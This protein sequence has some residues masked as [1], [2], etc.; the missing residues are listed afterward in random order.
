LYYFLL[1]AQP[2]ETER[3]VYEVVKGVLDSADRM[4]EELRSYPGA[5]Q[6][7]REA[8]SNPMNEDLQEIAWREVVPLVGKL[9]TFYEY[10]TEL[11]SVLPQLLH[12]L[13]AGPDTPIEHLEKHQALAKQ[14]AEIL[15]FTLKFDDL[16]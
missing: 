11:E 9:K 5:S 3:E 7:I 14:F 15:H 12:A 10:A 6:A 4:L 13:C 8:I 2:T 16:K 1:D